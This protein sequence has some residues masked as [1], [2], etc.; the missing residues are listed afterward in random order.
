M[1]TVKH[2]KVF[3]QGF[4]LLNIIWFIGSHVIDSKALPNPVDVY[5][6]LN[7]LVEKNIM[8]HI[9]AST[10]RVGV[11][12]CIS[13]VIGVSIGL[14]MGSSKHWNRLLN[15]LLYFTYP[16]PKTALLPVVMIL[17]GLGDESKIMLIVLIVVFPVIVAVRDAVINIP[18]VAYS[19]LLSLGA[20]RMQL[21]LKVTLPAM[22]P[23]LLTNI[24][25]SVGSA[26][27]VLFFAE[28]YGTRFGLGY[29][30]Q[31]SWSRIDYI[32]MYGGIIVL[33]LLGFI[34]FMFIDLLES[35]LCQWKG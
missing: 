12:L 22:L 26:L 18:K 20:S 6:S 29:F 10:Y 33:S 13:L 9:L 27:S 25:L 17:C 31:D 19:P 15:P 21:F 34:L 28:A 35:I 24:R 23:D 3:L 8:Q 11:G 16:I 4:L 32:G 14:L 7:I 1:K 30:I 5:L 2:I